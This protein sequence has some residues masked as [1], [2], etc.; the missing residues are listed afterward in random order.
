MNERAA[1]DA[2]RAYRL[3][4][5]LRRA[6]GAL[7]SDTGQHAGSSVEFHD[8][9]AY[10]PGDDPRRID[11]AVYGRSEELTVRLYREEIH[12]RVDI[13]LDVSRSMAL[14]DGEKPELARELAAFAWH[15]ARLQGSAVRLHAVGDEPVTCEDPAR[16]ELGA[17]SCALFHDAASCA[18]RLRSGGLRLVIS[19][20]M[21]DR[22][23]HSVVRE[24]AAGAAQLVVLVTLGPWEANP[25]LDGAFA[26][27][28]AETRHDAS[29]QVGER[30]LARYR[31]RL[32]RLHQDLQRSCRALSARLAIVVCDAPLVQVLRR[33]LLP[34]GVVSPV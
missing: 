20:F 1:L 17:A 26:L 14:P 25:E 27:E 32:A 29:I 13:V 23:V 9:R 28:D 19:D 24:L 15:S 34:A 7:G 2:C 6:A 21:T 3:E 8:Y 16:L 5:S 22:P 18:R 30:T 12:P 10:Q 33:D 4:R 31:E 11:W